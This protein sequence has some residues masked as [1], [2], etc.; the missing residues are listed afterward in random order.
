MTFE[1][2]LAT[3]SAAVYA[4]F[5][6]P[7]LRSDTS[8]LDVG[9]GS[10]SITLGLAPQVRR[11]LGVD[12]DD[13]DFV[14]ARTYA[15][16]HGIDNV[17][18][19]AGSVYA[20]GVPDASFDACLAHSLLEALDRPLEAL[21]ETHRALRPGG[22]VGVASV[23]YGGLILAG[24][25]ERL[26]RRFY[27]IRERLWLLDGANPFLGR[28]LRGL[29]DAAGFERIDAATTSMSYGTA[30]SV[31][32]FGLGRAE[33]CRDEWYSSQAMAHALA[34]VEDLSDM[35]RAWTEWSESA[36]AYASFSWCRAIGFTPDR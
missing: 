3:R 4:D 17:E 22:V 2:Q 10:G 27:E 36:D 1:E 26:L 35:E 7:H 33:E 30:E 6:L 31:R 9:C 21:R 34:T 19:R 16:E 18:F 12:V 14:D 13:D 11:V 25:H 29:L 5:L 28:T 23:E 24:V 8:L 15:A 20:L 32:S